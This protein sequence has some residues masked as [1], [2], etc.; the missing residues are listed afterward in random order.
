MYRL[1]GPLRNAVVDGH[2]L[3]IVMPRPIRW[4]DYQ[5]NDDSSLC[6]PTRRLSF[7]CFTV[8][9]LSDPRLPP[10]GRTQRLRFWVGHRTLAQLNGNVGRWVWHGFR[11]Q[12]GRTL[13]RPDVM[14]IAP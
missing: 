3:E 2:S 4:A 1:E 12:Y 9:A 6:M 5:A 14:W 8:Q 11:D 7:E 13:M 10:W